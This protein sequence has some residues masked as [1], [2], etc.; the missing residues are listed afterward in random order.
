MNPDYEQFLVQLYQKRLKGNNSKF[1]KFM[2]HFTKIF[3]FMCKGRC[4]HESA[5]RSKE[6]S[7]LG[8]V[9]DSGSMRS[10]KTFKI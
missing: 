1:S 9:R 5:R 10:R 6:T 2:F 8:V 3:K 7:E 4:A